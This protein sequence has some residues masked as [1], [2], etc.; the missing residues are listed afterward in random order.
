MV[1][2]IKFNESMKKLVSNSDLNMWSFIKTLA[3]KCSNVL[4][5]LSGGEGP[6]FMYTR[7]AIIQQLLDM[8][9]GSCY[10]WPARTAN[11]LLVQ[12]VSMVMIN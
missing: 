1:W 7:G 5:L 6:F 3:L 4:G 11:E 10:S 12:Y 9:F 2:Y 8:R